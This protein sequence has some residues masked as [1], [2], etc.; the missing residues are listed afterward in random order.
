MN[1]ADWLVK[2]EALRPEVIKLGLERIAEVALRLGVCQ[3]SGCQLPGKVIIVAGTNGKGSTVA[4]LDALANAAGYSTS[5]YT[6]PHLFPFNERISQ[7]GSAVADA[8]LCTAFSAVDRKST[9]LNSS[10]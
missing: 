6:S 3:L 5:V 4:L 7:R 10:H 1:L 2:I 9:R 8:D